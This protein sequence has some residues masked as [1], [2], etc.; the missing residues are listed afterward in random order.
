MTI[1][2]FDPM[3]D[4]YNIRKSYLTDEIIKGNLNRICV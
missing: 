2:N 4:G 1:F 3:F